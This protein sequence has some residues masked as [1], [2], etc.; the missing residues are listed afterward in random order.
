LVRIK[1]LPEWE[2]PREK[3][4]MNGF[5]ALSNV[6]VLAIVIGSGVKDYSALDIASSLIAKTK[7]LH[8]LKEA[9]FD[10]IC[11]VSGISTIMALRLG[12]TFEL[13]RRVEQ[14]RSM[15]G[16][17]R[18][19]APDI[20]KKYK[21]EIGDSPQ[22][23]FIIIFLS[24]RGAIIG[25][26]KMY[27]GTGDTFPIS[28]REIL[29]EVLANRCLSFTIV[30][31]HPSGDIKPSDNDLIATKVLGDEASRLKILL[32][33]HVIIGRDEYYSFA[34]NHLIDERR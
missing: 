24:R 33:D 15:D 6:E 16:E 19:S 4:L 7:G 18:L 23:H 9:S 26:N 20:F 17:R 2:R 27:K 34:E 30:H 29:S 14:S 31:N 13:L 12:A 11:D 1:D 22:E 10:K 25:E 8:Q 32:R 28:I 5:G 21:D 3:A